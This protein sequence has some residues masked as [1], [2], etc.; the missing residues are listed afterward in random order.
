GGNHRTERRLEPGHDNRL[1]RDAA[2]GWFPEKAGERLAEPALRLVSRSERHVVECR[3]PFDGL[4]RARKPARPA[5]GVERQAVAR[6]EVPP[7]R[8]R[9]Q[10]ARAEIGILETPVRRAIDL[11]EQRCEPLRL[12]PKLEGPAPE[13]GPIAGGQ[14]LAR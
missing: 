4:E 9:V 3:A 11:V 10:A 1:A 8:R 14:R 12:M 6:E 13:A 7:D 5:V 2:A